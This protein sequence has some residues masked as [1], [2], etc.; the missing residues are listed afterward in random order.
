MTNDDEFSTTMRID[1]P[2][3][4]APDLDDQGKDKTDRIVAAGHAK[5][6]VRIKRQ[7]STTKRPSPISTLLNEIYE[8]V[9]IAD[10]SG[11]VIEAN[12]RAGDFL[13]YS[14]AEFATF[15]IHQLISG[16]DAK[17]AETLRR[18]LEK[19]RFVL[20]QAFCVRKDGTVF[21]AEISTSLLNF[22]DA[23]LCLFIRDITVRREAEEMLRTGYNAIN[24][25]ANGI[26]VADLAGKLVYVNQAVLDLWGL[27]SAVKLVG[28]NIR[29][30]WV[31]ESEA[32]GMVNAV[33][34]RQE[35]WSG[36]L[37]ALKSDGQHRP[38]GVTA[39]PNRDSD[40]VLSGIVL[41][42]T[43]VSDRKRAEEAMRQ[44][45][46]TQAMLASLA[47]A[48]HHLSQPATVLLGNLTLLQELTDGG[49][50]EIAHRIRECFRA[51]EQLA[52]ILHRLKR[53]NVYRTVNYLENRDGRD[54]PSN[55]IL[56]LSVA[57]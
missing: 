25:S 35:P 47:A 1:I 51:A 49:N 13:Q 37:V 12:D 18:N 40:D 48:S 34:A 20:I 7:K 36:E 54:S 10:L 6:V 22:E 45:E 17:L 31:S 53:I 41:S 3:C 38:I 33:T 42:F 27:P 29:T 50:D 57:G 21:P 4:P 15:S 11:R 30:L 14:P 19:D 5:P 24:N 23:R 39:A 9:L 46:A 26:A 28:Q 52:E 8:G 44:A 55:K 32:E 16:A 2:L 43:D 56:D